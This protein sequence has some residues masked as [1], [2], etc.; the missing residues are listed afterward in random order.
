M[1]DTPAPLRKSGALPEHVRAARA[2]KR[3]EAETL[4]IDDAFISL[5]VETFYSSVRADDRLGPIFTAHVNDWD[6]HLARLKQFWR[7]VLHSSGEF[8]GNPMRTHMALP[9]LAADDFA[10]WLEL[11]YAALVRLGTSPA[12][13]HEIGTRARMIADSLL[14]GIAMQG[15]G[16]AGVRAGASLPWPPPAA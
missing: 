4:G 3:A 13:I 5:L 9:T 1:T 2:R 16:L 6:A 14:T 15:G 12:A 8:T 11:F 7:S 10:H